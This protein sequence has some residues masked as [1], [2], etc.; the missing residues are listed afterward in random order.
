M[1]REKFEMKDITKEAFMAYE[2]VR[3]S[4][5]TNMWDVSYVSEL[6]DLDEDVIFAIMKNYSA[7]NEKWP[8]VRQ[9]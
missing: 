3:A 6:S 4:G 9:G 2:R 5:V 8:E 1:I 7:L